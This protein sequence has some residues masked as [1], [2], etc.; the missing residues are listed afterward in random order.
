LIPERSRIKLIKGISASALNRKHEEVSTNLVT[1]PNPKF[2]AAQGCLSGFS[3]I[4]SN[5]QAKKNVQEKSF[6]TLGDG[7][8]YKSIFGNGVVNGSD[9]KIMKELVYQ[10]VLAY[11]DL[12]Y[13][14]YEGENIPVSKKDL[15]HYLET[16][17]NKDQYISL[18]QGFDNLFFRYIISLM[19]GISI[20]LCEKLN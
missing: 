5:P 12:I 14:I 16:E 1:E 4:F 17:T 15:L 6:I 2:A 9:N 19:E 10:N 3:Q 18:N 8:V 11:I 13:S 20:K 7:H